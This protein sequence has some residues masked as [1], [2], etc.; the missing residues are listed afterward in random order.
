MT[1]E[2]CC[3]VDKGCPAHQR[4]TSCTNSATITI[5]W[6]EYTFRVCEPCLNSHTEIEKA[7]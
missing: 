4:T 5:K 7:Q 2:K 3:C 6:R 1:E